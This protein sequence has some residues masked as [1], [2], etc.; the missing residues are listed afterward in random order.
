MR[1]R[2]CVESVPFPVTR[3]RDRDLV[4]AEEVADLDAVSVDRGEHRLRVVGERQVCADAELLGAVG[5]ISH[6][7]KLLGRATAAGRIAAV[8]SRRGPGLAAGAWWG[9]GH[10]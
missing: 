10:E 2:P 1:C 8:G 3:E 5:L 9:A 6:R 4:E 7:P